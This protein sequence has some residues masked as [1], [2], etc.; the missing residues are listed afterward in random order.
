M[1]LDRGFQPVKH[2][3]YEEIRGRRRGE[4]SQR[5]GKS[6]VDPPPRLRSHSPG[7]VTP[8]PPRLA[9]G[10]RGFTR[11]ESLWT[12]GRRSRVGV[13]GEDTLREGLM[14]V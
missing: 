1:E 2:V 11:R 5:R 14:G 4:R 3:S 10:S 9:R 7:P 13:T 12:R 8:L 6:K